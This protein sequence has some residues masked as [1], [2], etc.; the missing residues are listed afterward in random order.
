MINNPT[1]D[2]TS[3]RPIFRTVS[4]HYGSPTA[5]IGHDAVKPR[6][7]SLTGHLSSPCVGDTP[8]SADLQVKGRDY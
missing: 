1:I 7:A 4:T 6:P 5:E 8:D 3:P 2:K